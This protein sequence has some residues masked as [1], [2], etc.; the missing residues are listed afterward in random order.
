M[1]DEDEILRVTNIKDWIRRK[2]EEFAAMPGLMSLT[3]FGAS[4][5]YLM[6]NRAIRN[7]LEQ[8]ANPETEL[9]RRYM[10]VVQETESSD[11]SDSLR[12]AMDDIYED[13]G[14]KKILIPIGLAQYAINIWR[15]GAVLQDAGPGAGAGDVPQRGQDAAVSVPG[16][17]E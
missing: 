6:H 16:G 5:F 7:R 17:A 1:A 4:D 3:C 13:A 15:D 9:W 11:Y 14:K 2:N 10:R 8:A 12:Q